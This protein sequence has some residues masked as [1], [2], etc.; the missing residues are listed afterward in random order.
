M[1]IT[2]FPKEKVEKIR[3]MAGNLL[4]EGNERG[5]ERDT[6]YVRYPPAQKDVLR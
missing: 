4:H 1:N 5:R 3:K 6:C 2:S